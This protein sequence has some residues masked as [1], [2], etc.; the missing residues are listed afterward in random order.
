MFN[1]VNFVYSGN[2]E[3]G[4][5]QHATQF[6]PELQKLLPDVADTG[7]NCNI[8]LATVNHPDFY[9]SYNGLKVAFCVWESTEFP[10]DFFKQ[11]LTFDQL[12]VPSRWAA[13]CAVAQGYPADRVKVVPE[14]VDGLV[15]CPGE[16]REKNTFDFLHVGRWEDRKSTKEI[17]EAF[18]K[19]FPKRYHPDV[20]LI[21]NVDNPFP[22]DGMTTTEERM[23]KYGFNDD[24]L[25]IVPHLSKEQYIHYLQN[26]DCFVTCARAEGWNL[27]LIEAMS[28]GTPSI[29]SGYGAQLAF[30]NVP[31]LQVKI[32]DHKKPVHVYNM[33]DCPGTWAEPDYDNLCDVMLEVYKNHDH[34]DELFHSQSIDFS[35]KWA[36]RNAAAIA[37]K[38]LEELDN[39]TKGLLTVD[40]H[41]VKG[42]FIEIKGN[43]AK[44][45]D[46]FFINNDTREEIY[47]TKLGVNSWSKIKTEYFLNVGMRVKDGDKIVF[48]HDYNPKGKRVFVNMDSKALGDTLAWIP[49]CEEFRKKW[50]CKMVVSTFNNSLIAKVYPEIEFVKPGASVPDIYAQYSIGV[51]HADRESKHPRDWRTVPLQRVASDILGLEYKEIR[52]LV[53]M[54]NVYTANVKRPKKYICISEHSTAACKY[55]HYPNGWQI[56]TDKLIKMG[57]N[58][59]SI[60]REPTLLKNVIRANGNHIDVTMGILNGCECYIGLASGLAWLSWAMKKP[61]VMIS[62]FSEPFTEFQSG[63]TRIE[64]QGD[65]VGCL[66][67]VFI[68]DR[69]WDEGCFHNQ[70]Y[71]CTAQI[72][73]DMVLERMGLQPIANKL[74]FTTAPILRFSRR[75]TTFKTFL[76]SLFEQFDKPNLVEIGTLRRVPTDPDLPG[77]GASTAVLSWYAK[78]YGGH[79]TAVDLSEESLKNC[80]TTLKTMGLFNGNLK[81]VC[82]DGL[83]FLK[84]YKDPIHGIYIDA[85]DWYD[86]ERGRQSE[87]FHLNALKAAEKNMVSGSVVMFDDVFD[88]TFRGKGKLAIPYAIE[89][90]NYELLA[91][92][93]QVVLR[94]K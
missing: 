13:D 1:R 58:V 89:S 24:R 27:P 55:W 94:R 21:L 93:Y 42:A 44:K 4:Y 64:G 67:D 23:K 59:V 10:A 39:D 76:K 6:W 9:K 84:K 78:S 47:K 22:V 82:A 28:C 30:H 48:S 53:D 87:L 86:D 51:Y 74:D 37:L 62:G 43:S 31:E 57:Y 52:P 91:K 36:W 5:G 66:N 45:Y 72:T 63:I 73:P 17:I 32:A 40:Y 8:V 26:A 68:H 20:R 81:L 75:Q 83:S 11:L 35:N 56:L 50:D 71:S 41:F 16:K 2:A 18:L 33:P 15:Y 7:V 60:S 25:V 69:A 70:K 61:V 14:G 3:S 77:D 29:C 92:D 34:Y 88:D 54:S 12:W 46:V 19:A 80:E 65:C 85:V 79:V 49:Y 38:A 90:G